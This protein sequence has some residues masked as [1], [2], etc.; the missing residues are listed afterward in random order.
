MYKVNIH[1]L[2]EIVNDATLPVQEMMAI[3]KEE[4]QRWEIENT[5]MTKPKKV[6]DLAYQGRDIWMNDTF[7]KESLKTGFKN[8]DNVL[9]GINFGELLVIGGRPAMGKTQ[10]LAHLA[11]QMSVSTP[12]LF[13]SYDASEFEMTCRFVAAK[14]GIDRKKLLSNNLS[15]EIRL[16]LRGINR[17]M[18]QHQIFLSEDYHNSLSAFTHF[19]ETQIKEQNIKVIMMDNLQKVSNASFSSHREKEIGHWIRALKKIAQEQQVAIIVSSQLS[20]AVEVRPGAKIPQLSDLSDSGTI[21]QVADK[22]LLMYRPEYYKIEENEDS[23]FT[24]GLV[25]M[26]L[27]KNKNGYNDKA[28]LGVNSNFTQ[29]NNFNENKEEFDFAPTRM[30]EIKGSDIPF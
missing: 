8:L 28:Y 18:E 16:Q 23:I 10:F 4:V 20:R 27:A 26:I 29:F 30:E 15:S 24:I 14:S 12:T 11:L 1:K 5:L 25:E 6:A 3:L 9:E 7:Q 13:F 22:V 2:Q 21:E 17:E 19:C